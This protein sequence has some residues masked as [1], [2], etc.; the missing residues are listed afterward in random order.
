MERF[1]QVLEYNLLRTM[2]LCGL[3][4]EMLGVCLLSLGVQ[5]SMHSAWYAPSLALSTSIPLQ[6]AGGPKQERVPF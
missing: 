2:S 3:R 4:L 5:Q 6:G 1:Q